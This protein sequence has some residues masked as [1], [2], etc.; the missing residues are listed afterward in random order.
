MLDQ[1]GDR[2][3]CVRGAEPGGDTVGHDLGPGQP[4]RW[5]VE[6]EPDRGGR[7]R[8]GGAGGSPGSKVAP[9]LEQLTNVPGSTTTGTAADSWSLGGPAAA[10]APSAS[11]PP[12]ATRASTSKGATT[13][14]GVRRPA[15]GHVDGPAAGIEQACLVPPVNASSAV[16]SKARGHQALQSK[17]GCVTSRRRDV[18][19][20]RQVSTR[21]AWVGPHHGL[22]MLGP[23]GPNV[24]PIPPESATFATRTTPARPRP[25]MGVDRLAR[26]WVRLVPSRRPVSTAGARALSPTSRS[27]AGRSVRSTLDG[28][29]DDVPRALNH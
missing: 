24:T 17:A 5:C 19:A 7:A 10:T 21:R 25:L 28:W 15:T 26:V 14:Q 12:E 1:R 16:N 2:R 9:W 13:A 6:A 8:G 4:A 23:P 3:A 18:L 27:C 22:A 11:E 20:W 29:W